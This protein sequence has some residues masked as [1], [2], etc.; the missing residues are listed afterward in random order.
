VEDEWKLRLFLGAVVL[1]SFWYWIKWWQKA[2]LISD[3]PRSRIRSAAQGYVELRGRGELPQSQPNLAPLTKRPCVWWMYKIEHFE[4]SGKSSHWHTINNGTSG[5][6]F[7]LQDEDHWCV[8]SPAG[9]DVYPSEK[10]VWRGN[11]AWPQQLPA[12]SAGFGRFGGGDYR[13]TEHRIY[14]HEQLD[15]I[16]EF[17]S[18]GGV[19]SVDKQQAVAELLRQWKENQATLLRRFDTN[20]DGVL[21]AMEWEQ[22]RTAAQVEIDQ[23]VLTPTPASYNVLMKADDGRPFLIAAYDLSKVARRFRLYAALA[24]LIFIAA[25]F[26]LASNLFGA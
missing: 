15:V 2:R 8:V 20:H 18:V 14:E 19:Q 23:R 16:G 17:R 5:V 11:A 10:T 25:V 21:S 9:A 1:G 6:P 26:G 12:G 7:L 24:I 13:F 4:S 22:A 3:T